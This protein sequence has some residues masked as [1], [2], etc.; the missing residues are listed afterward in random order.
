MWK[1]PMNVTEWLMEITTQSH[2]AISGKIETEI[3]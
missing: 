1:V 2:Q 3:Y